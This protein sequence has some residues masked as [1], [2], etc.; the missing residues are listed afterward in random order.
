MKVRN[1]LSFLMF[2]VMIGGLVAYM[3][4]VGLRVGPPENRVNLAMDVSDINGIVVDSNVLL[5]GVPVGKV[6]GIDTTVP[7]STIHF[8]VDG[9]YRVPADSD[10]RLDNLSA[11]GETYIGLF[12]RSSGGPNLRDGQHIA[13]ESVIQPPSISE[14]AT[15]MVR[16]LNG[17]DPEQLK[18]IVAE[19]DT[20]LPDPNAVL[21][22]LS[23]SSQLL[24]NAVA[25]M[26]GQGQDVLANLQTLLE[27]AGFV[28]PALA[29]ASPPMRALGPSVQ[30]LWNGGTM[31]TLRNERHVD[32]ANLAHLVDRIQKLLDDRGSDIRVLS[33]AL[34]PNMKA[35]V[36]SLQTFD[37]GQVLG[38]ILDAVP[39]DG[40]INLHI[41]IPP[42]APPQGG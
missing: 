1:L 21:P 17:M 28:G 14:L 8:Y 25:D 7:G 33:E 27:N 39:E 40:A 30:F 42:V 16:V 29:D 34:V 15:S 37:S 19:A 31:E 3:A 2:A 12:P 22:N 10:V 9:A 13:T 26:N 6:T 20:G 38:N 5:R 23:R 4:S 11:L 41:T 18:R 24:R 32:L 35:I 36:A